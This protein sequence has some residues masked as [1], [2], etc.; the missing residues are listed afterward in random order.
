VAPAA[1]FREVSLTGSGVTHE[2]IQN[3]RSPTGRS[4]LSLHGC[5]DAVKIFGKG[6]DIIGG[7]CEFRHRGNA[8][9]TSSIQDDRTN[10]FARLIRQ[11]HRRPKQIGPALIAAAEVRAVAQPAVGSVES[12]A[13]CDHF[14]IARWALLRRKCCRWIADAGR[15]WSGATS[16]PSSLGG[17]P[18]SKPHEKNQDSCDPME[19]APQQSHQSPQR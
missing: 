2:H 12:I 9:I 10:Q 3:R 7:Q 17:N 8:W 1:V 4:A 14:G 15:G 19:S 13:A 11:H 18:G 5:G 6:P 16:V